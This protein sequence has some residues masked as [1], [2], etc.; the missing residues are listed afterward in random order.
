M[1]TSS[2]RILIIFLV[3]IL[4]SSP[5]AFAAH[6]TYTL[7]P[8]TPYA[9]EICI[10]TA[11]ISG[12]AVLVLGG[13]HGNE[14]AGSLAAERLCTTEVQRGTL[15]VI[16]RVNHLALKQNIRTLPEI[17]DI[18]RAYPGLGESPAH[19]IAGSI[20]ELASRHSISLVIDMHE[21]RTFHRLDHESLGQSVLFANNTRST[22]L[23]I[24]LVDAI[25]STLLEPHRKF[26]LVA[27]PAPFSAAE[28]FGRNARIAAFTME[29]SSKQP[30]GERVDQHI[31]L[32][33][34]LLKWEGLL[35]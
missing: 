28:Y 24:D 15:V 4:C 1:K 34:A 10:N 11:P 12:P 25:N 21:A 20:V 30:V 14:P 2:P 32:V 6:S 33:H 3:L 17:G 13:V 7:L 19:Q 5:L 31:F 18:N 8:D 26:S 22:D 27:H 29:T 16:P 9:T 35:P 23:A